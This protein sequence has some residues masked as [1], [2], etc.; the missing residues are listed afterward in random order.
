MTSFGV[1]NEQL[2]SKYGHPNGLGAAGSTARRS[3]EI[4]T[5]GRR[6][7]TGRCFTLSTALIA[8]FV[9]ALVGRFFRS[10]NR[11]LILSCRLSGSAN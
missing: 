6:A 5:A 3:S 4:Y 1:H 10:W 9:V 2:K 11:L 7:R 8:F